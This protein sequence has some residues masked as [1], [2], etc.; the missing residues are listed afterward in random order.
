MRKVCEYKPSSTLFGKISPLP[1]ERYRCHCR[2]DSDKENTHFNMYTETSKPPLGSV[3]NSHSKCFKTTNFD[4][5]H[6]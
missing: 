1:H 6:R 4:R 2:L 5:F 3:K